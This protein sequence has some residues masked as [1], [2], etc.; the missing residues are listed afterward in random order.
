[1]IYDHIDNLPIY[2][3]LHPALRGVAEFLATVETSAL[4]AGTIELGDDVRCI[5]AE[6]ETAEPGECF[7]ECHRRYIDIH[8]PLEGGERLGVCARAL[9]EAA[10]VYDEEKDYQ[11]LNGEVSLLDLSPG[12]FALFFPDDGHMTKL[13]KQAPG[14]AVRK[15]IFKLP[16]LH[17]FV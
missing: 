17:P 14:E 7:I 8:V 16:V 15:L 10:G 11:V 2:A 3:A 5:V 13:P 1:M 4:A 6:Y 9:S 12:M